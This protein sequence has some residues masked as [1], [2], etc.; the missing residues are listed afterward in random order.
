MSEKKGIH[1]SGFLYISSNNMIYKKMNDFYLIL[2]PDE[3]NFMVADETGKNILE[4]CNVKCTITELMD[5]ITTKYDLDKENIESYIQSLVKAGFLRRK[6]AQPPRDEIRKSDK[7]NSLILH[8]TEACNLRCKHCYFE[9]ETPLQNE[10]SESEF[11]STIKDFARLGGTQLLITGGEPLLKKKLLYRVIKETTEQG[12]EKIVIDTNG[13]LITDEDADIFRKYDVKVGVSLDGATSNTHDYIR[14]KGSFEKTVNGIITLVKSNV[15]VGIGLT[16]MKPNLNE[17]EEVIYLAKKLGVP[18][19][20]FTVL[21][22]E[23]R[24]KVNEDT[25]AFS[26]EDMMNALK[27]ILKAS[28]KAGIKTSVA[29]LREIVRHLKKR[30]LCGAGLGLLSIAANGDVYPCDALQKDSLKAGNIRERS[31]EEIWKK[32]PILKTFQNLSVTQIEKCQQCELKFICGGGCLADSYVAYEDF[33]KCSPFCQIYK[34]IYWHMISQL[35]YDL[36]Q[37]T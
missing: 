5:F 16:L 10:M 11:L 7:L 14:G 12:I 6:P 4:L 37:Q 13:T 30:D 17:V 21:K 24:A 36:W 22:I 23:G 18:S 8:L 1:S 31:L 20:D 3:P 32:S 27:T 35:A 28:K 15:H 26:M 2:N 19:V 33:T 9:C 25:L 29:E 34:G